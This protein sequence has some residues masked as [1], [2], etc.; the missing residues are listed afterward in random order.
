MLM[1]IVI[2]SGRSDSASATPSRPS[3]PCPPTSSCGSELMICCNTLHMNGESSTTSTRIFFSAA[4]AISI[5]PQHHAGCGSPLG[6]F[7]TGQALDGCYQL[8]FLYGLCQERHR[9][10]FHGAV[11]VL[12]AGARRHHQDRNAA[13]DGILSQV[14]HQFVAVHAR[15]FEVG[16]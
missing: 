12:G 1:S 4:R 2:T 5:L 6:P 16:D 11:A 14:R 9:A 15:H 3:R 13:R 8:V 10:L 7:G